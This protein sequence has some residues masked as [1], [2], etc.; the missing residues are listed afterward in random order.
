M[1][2]LRN[3]LFA[4]L[5]LCVFVGC[6]T[7]ST[8]QPVQDANRMAIDTLQIVNRNKDLA[9]DAFVEETVG[10]NEQRYAAEWR[11]VEEKLLQENG[12]DGTVPLDRYK[13]LAAAYAAEVQ[14]GSEYYTQR[15]EALKQQ[16]SAQ[17]GVALVLLTTN[18][19][20]L[21]AAGIPPEVL[22]SM[23]NNAFTLGDTVAN[24]LKANKEQRTL[25]EAAKKEEAKQGFRNFINLVK[26][27]A[28]QHATSATPTPV[29]EG[30]AP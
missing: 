5:F 9:I 26:E 2:S 3:R 15:G 17:I 19:E 30:G 7:L 29:V 12:N 23:L 28:I 25:A 18:A 4:L 13:T 8:P 11:T 6:G 10:L 21:E 1:S 16:L 20:F 27:Y 22:Q 14:K 24:Q